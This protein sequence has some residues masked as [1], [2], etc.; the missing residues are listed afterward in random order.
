MTA[1]RVNELIEAADAL[2][3]HLRDWLRDGFTAWQAGADLHTALCL[4]G[5]D[6][7]RRGDLIKTAVLLSP[8]E[9]I[10]AKA[11]YFISCLDG[12]QHH[13]RDDMQAIIRSL[14]L[15][16]CPRSI[17]QLRRIVEGRRQD[18]WREREADI[19][20]DLCPSPVQRFNGGIFTG[21]GTQTCRD[22]FRTT[23]PMSDHPPPAPR[24]G[25]MR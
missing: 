16:S 3:E 4:A 10:T 7:D 5:P 18:G 22:S 17:K 14:R 2:Q 8:G 11:A 19:T 21:K 15:I 23:A 1:E 25:I 9:S 13:H 24:R 6:P 12:Y 20:R